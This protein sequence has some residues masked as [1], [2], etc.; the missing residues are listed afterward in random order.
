[1]PHTVHLIQLGFGWPE[2]EEEDDSGGWKEGAEGAGTELLPLEEMEG[3]VAAAERLAEG[4]NG[5]MI[6]VAGG[7]IEEANHSRMIAISSMQLCPLLW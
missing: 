4:V 6:V 1:M 3:S 2:R 5:G 7:I